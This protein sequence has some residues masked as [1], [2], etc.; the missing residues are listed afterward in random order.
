MD[1][2][3]YT[4]VAVRNDRFPLCT[5]QFVVSQGFDPQKMLPNG[6]ALWLPSAVAVTANNAVFGSALH[7]GKGDRDGKEHH[8]LR[9]WNLEQSEP[10]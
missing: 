9:G 1:T 3:V 4:K 7:I 10:G 8:I 2:L 6:L 5:S